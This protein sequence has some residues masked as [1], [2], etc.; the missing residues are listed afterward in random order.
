MIEM[1]ENHIFASEMYKLLNEFDIRTTEQQQ[2]EHFMLE[3]SWQALL[4]SLEM[5]ED[6]HKTRKSHFIKELSKL[7]PKL[8]E[9]V[10]KIRLALED[11]RIRSSD[12]SSGDVLEYLDSVSETLLVETN[13]SK[14]YNNY[15][16][17]MKVRDFNND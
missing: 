17:L 11:S 1:T 10:D 8:N 6:T 9:R 4:D 5:C 15:Q 7:V 12:V 3:Q 2:T 13:T 16:Q 14:Q